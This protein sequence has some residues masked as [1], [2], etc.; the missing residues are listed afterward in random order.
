MSQSPPPR[1]IDLFSGAGG[2]SLGF[3]AAGCH[4]DAAVDKDEAAGRT[5]RENFGRLQ[6]DSAPLVFC[7]D[8]ADLSKFDMERL[9]TGGR[10]DILIGGPPC[11]G[12]SRVGR[13]KLDDLNDEGYADDPR[14]ELFRRFLDIAELWRPAAVVMENVPGMLSFDGRNVA[15]EVVS[16]MAGRGYI[17][18]YAVL[19]AVWY[20]VPQYRDRLFFVG[21]REDRGIKPSMPAA[22][23]RAAL[24]AGYSLPL[25]GVQFDFPFAAPYGELPVVLEAADFP[26]TTVADALEDLPVV[27]YHLES[28]ND[29]TAMGRDA[30]APLPY[31]FS[32]RSM[33]ARLMRTWPSL[34]ASSAPADHVIRHTPRDYEI[35]RAMRPGDRYPAALAIARRRFEDELRLLAVDGRAP[36]PETAEYRELQRRFIPPYP[37]DKFVDKWRKLVPE[38]PSW[39]VTAHLAKDTYS[40]IHYDDVQARCISAR[41]AA[42]LQSFPDAFAFTGNMGER[43]SQIGN[44]VPP[45]LSWAVACPLLEALG[46]EPQHPPWRII[47]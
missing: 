36:L 29:A 4:I 15:H 20:G 19:N 21:I 41:E 47:A 9:V 8:D 26:A 32:P 38:Q 22:T 18:G 17:A 30:R 25:T 23:H 5:F 40:H 11:Q 28:Q 46:H 42:R 39:T 16:E 27:D 3:Q 24:P 37:H 2:F 33:F 45:L 44:A 13:A 12:F 1:V 6:A 10:P 7:G 14:N 34:A 43:F 31:R 35:F